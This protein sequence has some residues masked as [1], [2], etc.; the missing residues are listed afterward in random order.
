[1][2]I[3]ERLGQLTYHGACRLLSKDGDG[4]ARLRQ[5]GK[6]EILVPRDVR[7]L[8]D[9]FRVRIQDVDV[10][11]GIAEVIIVEMT[12][13]PK[14]L[15]LTC[16]NCEVMC[17]HIAAALSLVLDEKM[18]LGLAAPPDSSEP[19]EKL[20]ESELIRRTLA[21][22][23]ERAE[24]EPMKLKSM[25]K[26]TPWTDYTI[27]SGLS[28]KTYRVSLRGTEVGQSYCSCPDF[29]SN[30]LGTCKHILYALARINKRFRNKELSR[31]YV[32]KT[33]SLRVDYGKQIGLQFNMP[34][35]V[36]TD[37]AK[38]IGKFGQQPTSNAEE[39]VRRIGKLER[40]GFPVHVYPDADEFIDQRLQQTRLKELCGEIRKAPQSHPLRFHTVESRTVAVPTGR[41]RVR[42]WRGPCNTSGR[43]G[44]G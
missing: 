4:A 8:A 39:V 41:H 34:A 40:L 21:D 23:Q 35:E 37:A 26:S 9:S 31:P 1:M 14:G 19:L 5:G 20:T 12:N 28:G 30:H 36:D 33:L 18:T 2:G 42:C 10:P 25:D 13:K 6:F 24:R 27:T 17:D 29:R 43:H 11:G 32:R 15:H 22:R 3:R 7:F 38:I 16:T 44:V